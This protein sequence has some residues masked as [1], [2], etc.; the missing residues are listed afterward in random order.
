MN[1]QI[2]SSSCAAN[3]QACICA[4]AALQSE[5]TACV[6]ANCTVKESLTAQN[7]TATACDWPYRDQS[8]LLRE[9]SLPLLILATIFIAARVVARLPQL[10][11]SIG[12]DDYV[13]IAAWVSLMGSVGQ[14]LCVRR[15]ISDCSCSVP[16]SQSSSGCVGSP[17]GSSQQV[18]TDAFQ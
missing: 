11:G 17:F 2:P 16:A 3:N 15:L 7:A 6:M 14:D 5:I 8:P 1:E 13:I 10:G 9:I 4:N 18:H 12:S